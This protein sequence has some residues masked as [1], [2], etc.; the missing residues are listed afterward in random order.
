MLQSI[1]ALKLNERWTTG[2]NTPVIWLV[3]ACYDGTPRGHL[4]TIK[5]DHHSI[6]SLHLICDCR[7]TPT[8][9]RARIAITPRLVR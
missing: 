1:L 9:E 3:Q 8:N 5:F 6:D 7:I 2:L 4:A